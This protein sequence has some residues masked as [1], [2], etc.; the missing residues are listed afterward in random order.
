MKC[1]QR[2]SIVAAHR[3]CAAIKKV[4]DLLA[5]HES[6]DIDVSLHRQSSWW[7]RPLAWAGGGSR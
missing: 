6:S 5:R 7:P 1:R 2:Q 3:H 4:N